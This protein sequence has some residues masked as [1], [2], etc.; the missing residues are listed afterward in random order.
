MLGVKHV[1]RLALGV[2]NDER[3]YVKLVSL[4]SI[5]FIGVA[6]CGLNMALCIKV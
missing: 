2:H 5:L 3:L 1:K 4:K 6:L